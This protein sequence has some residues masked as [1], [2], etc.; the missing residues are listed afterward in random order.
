MDEMEVLKKAGLSESQAKV[1]YVLLSNG[2]L[3]PAEISEKCDET[4]ENCYSIVKKL[5][6][7]G[8]IEKTEAKKAT[9]RVLNPSNLEILAERRR[10]IVQKNEK[11]LKDNMSSLLDIF[12]AN[13]EMPGARTL[14]GIDGIKEVYRD[15][16]R[17]GKDIYLLRTRADLDLNKDG[18]L[19]DYRKKRGR[20]GITTY[21]LC[22]DSPEGRKNMLSGQDVSYRFNRTIMDNQ[23]SAP[24]EIDIYGNKVALISFGE[25]QMA[26]IITSPT[27]AEAMRQ[28]TKI[29]INFYKK[30]D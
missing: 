8:L 28:I 12:Y 11:F 27:I 14:E 26:T 7:M 2:E 15:T 17:V 3:T 29:L 9:Y 18:F 13:N 30:E 23:Y 5:D 1:Y 10:R 16:L 25:T 21:A 6:E 20:L 19:D 24:V 4:R 22:P